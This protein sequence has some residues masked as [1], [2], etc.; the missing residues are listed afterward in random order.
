MINAS[1]RGF[2]L[3]DGLFETLLVEDQQVRHLDA[4]LDRLAQG[5]LVIGLP[6]PERSQVESAIVRALASS[7][8]G[9]QALRL[10]WSAGLGGRGLDRPDTLAPG[11]SATCATAPLPDAARLV[12][13]DA[14]RRN[15]HSPASR[16]KTLSYLDNVLARE[17]ARAA[18]ANEAVMLNTAGHLACAAAANLFWIRDGR[19][20][21]PAL[22]CGALPGITRGRLMALHAVEAVIQGPDALLKAEAVFLTN[23]LN[24]VRAVERLDDRTLSPHPLVSALAAQL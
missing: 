23:S 13:A 10:T 21:T 11:L 24:G 18:G 15:E 8:P 16:L 5:C 3:G 9:R 22:G 17:E 2:T 19:V 1:D 6:A 12:I 4:H 14:V 20:F 7:G